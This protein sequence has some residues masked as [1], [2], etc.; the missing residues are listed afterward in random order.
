MLHTDGF[1]VVRV[2]ALNVGLQITSQYHECILGHP[3]IQ[4]EHFVWPGVDVDRCSD[5][6]GPPVIAGQS[7][8]CSSL[9]IFCLT[10][11]AAAVGAVCDIWTL[12]STGRIVSVA[13]VLSFRCSGLQLGRC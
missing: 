3:Q 11:K 1:P 13:T 7:P 8:H 10:T 4:L 2:V 5:I 6:P 12:L 9:I